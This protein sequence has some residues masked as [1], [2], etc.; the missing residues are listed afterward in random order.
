MEESGKSVTKNVAILFIRQIFTWAST[1]VLLLF[2]PR[3]LGPEN[4]GKYYLAQSLTM[5]FSVLIDFG[6]H[7]WITKEVSRDRERVGQIIVDALALRG[8]MWI[9]SF[10][11]IN[12][13]AL[14]VGYDS[15]TRMV[16]MIFGLG[17]IWS[18]GTG[19]ISSCYQGFELLRYPA[20]SSV[21]TSAFIS[22]VGVIAL[23]A[24]IG[25]IGFTVIT[26]L[27]GLLSFGICALFINKMTTHLPRVNW[28][29]SFSQLKH[30]IPYFL[31]TVFGTIY[32]R[33]D[34]IMLSLLTPKIVMGWYGASYRFF[35][36][37]M[38]VPSILSMAVF[39]AMSRLWGEENSVV[40]SFQKSIDFLFLIGVPISIGMFTFSKEIIEI[41]YG[42]SAY[43]PS[44]LLLKIFSCGML[45]VYIDIMLGTTLLATDNQFRVSMISL[46]AIFINV[47][48]NYF[49]IP[50]TQNAFG[51]GSIGSALATLITE[52]FVMILML[53]LLPK[54]IL[55]NSSIKVQLK[56]L[57][58]GLI[59]AGF[60]WLFN[61]IG[62]YWIIQII[63]SSGVYLGTIILLKV[64]DEK[65]IQL[66]K[67][68]IPAKFFTP[69]Q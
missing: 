39:P 62:I 58:S 54:S 59:M 64:I 14:M 1:F 19:V 26:V 27:G 63:L 66:L 3:Y 51:N 68:I 28:K 67:A 53:K 7:Y 35:D 9:L 32:Y 52:L 2:L 47:G 60:L 23:I 56:I 65:D 4:Y 50:V 36:A 30:G 17:M 37:L 21:A 29:N 20:Y 46:A 31:N 69:K 8:M 13:Y 44:V 49:L 22:I 15:E 43:E 18:A 33:V 61:R 16:V 48:L 11:G 55:E 25:P 10:I 24:G 12:L 45:I 57:A 38:F 42:L 6:G 41:F 5:I 34:A 40:K